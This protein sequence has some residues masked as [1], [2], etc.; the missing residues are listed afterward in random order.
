[1]GWK[2]GRENCKSF[3]FFKQLSKFIK[4][5]LAIQLVRNMGLRY[6]IFKIYFELKKRSG[7]M[8]FI[9]PV[10]PKKINYLN[11]E[12]W[13]KNKKQFIFNSSSEINFEIKEIDKAKLLKDANNIINA[14]FTF[15]SSVEYDL[16]KNYNWIQNPETGHTYNISKH[17]TEIND[18]SE[19]AGDIKYVWEK[20]RFTF[21]YSLIRDEQINKSNHAEFI[22]K[23]IE[24]WIDKNPINCGPNYKCSQ[25]ISLRILNWVFAIY[26]YSDKFKMD[27]NRWQKILNSI[28]WQFHHVYHNI[29]FSRIAVR[30]NH[31]ITE[32]LTLYIIG[33]LFPF[34][35]NSQKW[36]K[37]GKSWFE[38][39]IQYQ[40]Y[41]D[42]TFLQFSMNYHRVVVQL[43]T[44][45]IC[46][47]EKNK[48]EFGSI[49]YDRAYKSLNFLFQCQE[50]SNG[51][52]PNY[53]ANDGALFF[54]LTS[55]DFRDYRP[56]LN[57]LHQIITGEN[58][59]EQNGIWEE[60]SFWVN[61]NKIN[62]KK[63]P[64][65][66]KQMG[67]VKFEV[68][69]YYIIRDESTMSFIRCGNHKDRPSQADN[70]HLDLW[71]KG[72]NMLVDAGSY[73]YNTD[74]KTLKYFM[75]TE[76]HNT[77][78]IGDYDQ[79]LKGSRFIWYYW[80]QCYNADLHEIDDYYEFKGKIKAFQNIN[81]NIR[82]TRIV[83]KK[84]KLNH[85][86]IIDE[87]E[88]SI[89]NNIEI[90]QLWH[91]SKEEKLSIQPMS[92]Y[93]SIH[94]KESFISN[95]YGKKI[96][97]NHLEILFGKNK[98]ATKIEVI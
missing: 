73:K 89:P 75:G 47:A 1:V 87:I 25:E 85:W 40:I 10:S 36:A 65:L 16:G 57:T 60:D 70:L 42:G 39:E 94:Q 48:D 32:T 46:F 18:Y 17:W 35:K 56:Q 30:N 77:V 44:L 29:H 95:Y 63:Y 91:Y 78:I 14:K 93:E 27:E 61:S 20:S 62:L 90:K 66:I 37:K 2:N 45:G 53:G 21:L 6:T 26:Y 13:K 3:T 76:S 7:L 58:L 12:D 15:F 24:D 84:K 33:T 98:L 92:D 80:T 96:K 8:K 71:V 5:N 83:R 97:T 22:F 69:G 55:S 50:S 59:Y 49:V 82:H 81:S 51:K 34:F 41:E 11:F 64:R 28:Y 31:A 9:F 4:I 74:Q 38:K 68:G 43:L 23:E 19:T 54:P 86:E 67:C 52:L 88:G 79:M 72:D